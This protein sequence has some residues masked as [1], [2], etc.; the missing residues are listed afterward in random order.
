MRTIL[1][2]VLL[3]LVCSAS[4]APKAASKVEPKAAAPT[5]APS[6][7]EPSQA[8]VVASLDAARLTELERAV[9]QL[10]STVEQLSATMHDKVA[11][12]Q[13]TKL[14]ADALRADVERLVAQSQNRDATLSSHAKEQQ[15]VDAV[16]AA[17]L[18]QLRASLARLMEQQAK[19]AE[20]WD[21]KEY[22]QTQGERLL[23][24]GQQFVQEVDL[25]SIQVWS[26]HAWQRVSKGA[27]QLWNEV[28]QYAQVA[29][30]RF[31]AASHMNSAQ[32]QFKKA[33]VVGMD[34]TDSILSRMHLFDIFSVAVDDL[35]AQ[36]QIRVHNRL[37]A[38][39]L[40]QQ[41]S[42]T[43]SFA[44]V[45]ALALVAAATAL[46]LVLRVVGLVLSLIGY[47]LCCCKKQKKQSAGASAA[48]VAAKKK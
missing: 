3:A 17:E 23:A 38:F 10:S 27:V 35:L 40:D 41:L 33:K 45:V 36:S 24:A 30:T 18:A 11:A 20:P 39:G 22:F 16:H 9:Q 37:V 15:R 6:T 44:I 28:H 2:I 8:A 43:A 25:E 12:I 4:A 29:I 21:A 46:V 34:C 7:P 19:A 5:P 47:V 13:P 48:S 31:D 42:R 14:Q 26:Q 32:T 1:L